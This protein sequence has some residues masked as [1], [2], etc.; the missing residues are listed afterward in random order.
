[1]QHRERPVLGPKVVAPLAHAVRLVNRK[2]RQ[3][4]ALIQAVEQAQKTRRVQPL[5]RGVQQ[6]DVAGLQAQLHVLRFVKTQCGV[7][8]RRVHPRLVQRAHLV[9]H[10]RNQRRNYDGHPTPLLL[11]HDGRYL[12]AQ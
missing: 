11:A 4:P 2:Q 9:V 10:Q 12:V 8:K 6:G 1:M 3:V 5:G 7:E